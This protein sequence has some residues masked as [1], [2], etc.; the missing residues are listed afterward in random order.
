MPR[1][2]YRKTA[3]TMSPAIPTMAAPTRGI[4]S[5]RPRS[6]KPPDSGRRKT[7]GRY[8]SL[9]TTLINGR[10]IEAVIVGEDRAAI[11]ES[12]SESERAAF[13]RLDSAL[14]SHPDF[15]AAYPDAR[16]V[17]VDSM[18]GIGEDEDGRYYLRYQYGDH[19]T[20]FWGNIAETEK[21]DCEQGLVSIAR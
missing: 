5:P 18:R 17:R 8:Q 15:Q 21:V 9:D 12:L 10:E 7:E 20:E 16:L 2:R 6:R 4:A 1:S 19:S 11:E 14:R 13:G 3:S